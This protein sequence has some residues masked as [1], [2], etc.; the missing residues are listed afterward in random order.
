MINSDPRSVVKAEGHKLPLADGRALMAQFELDEMRF[1]ASRFA[2]RYKYSC[3]SYSDLTRMCSESPAMP[4]RRQ[5]MPRTTS[6][7]ATP[8]CEAS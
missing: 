1:V 6:S 2:R 8:A 4:G 7:I 3:P 5:Q